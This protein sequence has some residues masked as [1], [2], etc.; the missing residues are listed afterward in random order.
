[1]NEFRVLFTMEV[2][3]K[4]GTSITMARRM[5]LPFLPTSGLNII[6]APGDDYRVVDE[7]YCNPFDAE[8]FEI[9]MVFDPGAEVEKMKVLGWEILP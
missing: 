6:C 2:A 7:V 5:T 4:K 1:M 8:P 3:A 9:Y